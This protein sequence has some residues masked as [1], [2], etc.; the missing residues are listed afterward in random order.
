MSLDPCFL[1]I[2]LQLIGFV[3]LSNGLRLGRTDAGSGPPVT[4]SL[5]VDVIRIE[6]EIDDD[7]SQQKCFFVFPLQ[8]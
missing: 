5:R 7:Q 6:T 8:E 4:A 3:V 2:L 1:Q